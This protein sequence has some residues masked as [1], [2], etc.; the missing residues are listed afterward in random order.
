VG[1]RT[2]NRVKAVL[3]VRVW[4]TDAEGKPFSMMLY[5]LDISRTGA[6]IGGFRGKLNVGD[7]VG[8]QYRNYQVRHRVCWIKPGE[9]DALLGV[10]SLQPDKDIWGVKLSGAYQDDY[11]VPEAPPPRKYERRPND[12]RKYTRFPVTGVAIV[13]NPVGDEKQTLRLGDLSL[14][15]CF[16]ETPRPFPVGARLEMLI[17]VQDAEI[18]TVGAVR[19]CLANAGMGVEFT[20]LAVSEAKPLYALVKRLGAE[21]AGR[22]PATA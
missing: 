7:T 9:K 16:I 8:I 15:G 11:V 22:P 2:K 13:S 19:V 18:E 14:E 12:R 21:E 1:R 4:G 3:P 20:H 6:R 17:K 10:E 5:T